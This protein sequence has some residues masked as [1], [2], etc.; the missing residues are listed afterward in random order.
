[1]AVKASNQGLLLRGSVAVRSGIIV[2][3]AG[4]EDILDGAIWEAHHNDMMPTAGGSLFVGD[5]I[6]ANN[7]VGLETTVLAYRA[8]NSANPLQKKYLRVRCEMG[9]DS[10]A[11]WLFTSAGTISFTT[12]NHSGI[13]VP[14]WSVNGLNGY[15]DWITKLGAYCD[16]IPE[17]L[18]VAVG[19]GGMYSAEIFI[20]WSGAILAGWSGSGGGL[21]TTKD[22]NALQT[23][24]DCHVAAFPNTYVLLD[25]NKYQNVDSGTPKALTYT[26]AAIDYLVGECPLVHLTNAGM[27]L[28]GNSD[29]Y[30]L[31]Q[32][33]GPLGS[34][35]AVLS[36]QTLQNSSPGPPSPIDGTQAQ[37]AAGRTT[38]YQRIAGDG[39]GGNPHGFGISS[40]ELPD[41][42]PAFG[43]THAVLATLRGFLL[44]NGPT[45][46]IP[47][48]PGSITP[49]QQWGAFQAGSGGA[50]PAPIATAWGGKSTA[51]STT[52]SFATL[53]G[54]PLVAGARVVLEIGDRVA[55][56]T[57]I[58]TVVDTL[59]NT[60]VQSGT[61]T[62]SPL[63]AETWICDVTTGGTSTITITA[64]KPSELTAIATQWS[65]LAGLPMEMFGSNKGTGGPATVTAPQAS[66]A[67]ALVIAFVLA[68]GTPTLGSETFSPAGTS[69]SVPDIAEDATGGDAMVLESSETLAG[70]SAIQSYSASVTGTQAW[71]A[72][73]M[74]FAAAS[75][76]VLV[77]P[78]SPAPVQAGDTVLLSL[79]DRV[80]GGT[81]FSGVVDANNP[82]TNVFTL[83]PAAFD[84]NGVLRAEVWSC[85]VATTGTMLIEA[86]PVNGAGTAEGRASEWNGLAGTPVDKVVVATGSAS[87]A[88][89]T[90]AAGSLAGDLVYAT[91]VATGSPTLSSRA[92]TAGSGSDTDFYKPDIAE[93]STGSLN[94]ILETAATLAGA[95]GTQ[96]YSV[97]GPTGGWICIIVTFKGAAASATAPGAPT[98][99]VATASDG[100]ASGS[101]TPGP[102]NGSPTTQFTVTPFDVATSSS[103]TPIVITGSPPT[104]SF[105]A[106]GLTDGHP[107][108]FTVTQTNAIGTSAASAA[109]A[110]VTPQPTVVVIPPV[111]TQAVTI[112]GPRPAISQRYAELL[113]Q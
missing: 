75:N 50:A 38:L 86:T 54:K 73:I 58:S 61:R 70:T 14:W 31:M 90:T 8:W 17:I 103:L 82:T 9:N 53:T 100:S 40:C 2:P 22:L 95:T 77:L 20:R 47:P 5:G 12:P 83:V 3:P 105:T 80:S 33:Y 111:V 66:S 6:Q 7:G 68:V 94:S 49:V 98:G 32:S 24:L 62:G 42:N 39:S 37:N 92:F 34:G 59:N 97:S 28:T 19:L 29:V 71:I 1:M 10:T 57:T 93:Q 74:S 25:L 41:T 69:F 104:P 64:A 65:G 84:T 72:V 110:A 15:T 43:D 16:S 55:S 27:A 11:G 108:T 26:K 85:E 63:R 21:T 76:A 13:C 96:G 107:I 18:S 101:F 78:P 88:S 79:G 87:A 45:T 113:K 52:L 23:A 99:V 89:A 51:V 36:C 81:T 4:Y 102:D 112:P 30:A 35:Q 106:T 44:A 91:V 48:P 46:V 109:S 60:W 56:A 67:G